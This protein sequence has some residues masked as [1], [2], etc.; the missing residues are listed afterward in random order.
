MESSYTLSQQMAELRDAADACALQFGHGTFRVSY[1]YGDW[2]LDI[3]LV[4]KNASSSTVVSRIE[5][6]GCL[7][8]SEQ[9]VQRRDGLKTV[10]RQLT[11][12]ASA[13]Y[14]GLPYYDAAVLTQAIREA[15]A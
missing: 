1:G 7:S 3:K 8:V 11:V 9:Y 14:F 10:L 5:Y 13:G 2:S 15:V 4:E 12:L 6:G